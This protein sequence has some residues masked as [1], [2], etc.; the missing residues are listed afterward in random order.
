M[1]NLYYGLQRL[2]AGGKGLIPL[3]HLQLRVPVARRKTRTPSTLQEPICHICSIV[4][5]TRKE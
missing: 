3:N 2:T 5:V 4:T 1:R